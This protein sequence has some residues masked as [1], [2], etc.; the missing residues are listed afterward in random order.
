MIFILKISKYY[1]CVLGWVKVLTFLSHSLPGTSSAGLIGSFQLRSSLGSVFWI[2]STYIL[3][4]PTR[5]LHRSLLAIETSGNYYSV[6]GTPRSTTH[7]KL[8]IKRPWDLDL[9]N[10]KSMTPPWGRLLFPALAFLDAVSVCLGWD[11]LS[12]SPFHDGMSICFVLVKVIYKL[13]CCWNLV[14][15]TS[16]SFQKQI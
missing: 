16:H 2:Q 14:D 10:K 8:C 13:P 9:K 12:L 5:S 15:V 6:L 3:Y 4:S 1:S 11:L 7:R